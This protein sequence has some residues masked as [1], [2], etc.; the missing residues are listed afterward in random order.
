MFGEG[1]RGWLA[2][3]SGLSEL[4][5]EWEK[6]VGENEGAA[7]SCAGVAQDGI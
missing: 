5:R 1:G 6:S 7:T 2:R 3:P 4:T